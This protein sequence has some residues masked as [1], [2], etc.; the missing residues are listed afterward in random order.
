MVKLKRGKLN[1]DPTHFDS[2]PVSQ[3][4]LTKINNR[5]PHF[6]PELDNEEEDELSDDDCRERVKNY[7]VREMRKR[8]DISLELAAVSDIAQGI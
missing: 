4:L 3:K 1:R 7:K 6:S 8:A 2:Y 5:I